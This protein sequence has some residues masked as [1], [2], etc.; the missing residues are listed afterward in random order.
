MWDASELVNG[1]NT[2]SIRFVRFVQLAWF[3]LFVRFV[4]GGEV[5][6]ELSQVREFV[7][8]DIVFPRLVVR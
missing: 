2:G 6:E 4:R 5:V 8:R 3:R 1:L 7:I